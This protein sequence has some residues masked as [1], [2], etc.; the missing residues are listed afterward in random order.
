MNKLAV[1]AFT[2]LLFLSA[3]L[4]YLAKGSLND[5]LRSQVELQGHY[6][7]GQQAHIGQAKFLPESNSAQFNQLVLTNVKGYSQ[8]NVLTIDEITATLATPLTSTHPQQVSRNLNTSQIITV[9]KLTLNKV[10]VTLEKHKPSVSNSS[11]NIAVLTELVTL[12]LAKDYPAV[13][14]EVAAKLYAKEHPEL[15]AKLIN[16]ATEVAEPKKEIN[17]AIIASKA[18]KKQKKL[19]GKAQTRIAVQAIT[20][21]QLTLN[22]ID[23]EQTKVHQFNQVKLGTIGDTN[24]LASNQAGGEIL[25]VLLEKILTLQP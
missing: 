20:I 1:L 11:S 18:E 7:S 16:S 25:R 13:Y 24:G 12:Q 4:W 23:S 9:E 10:T 19:L 15:D 21:N 17:K 14:P 3:I 5:Y 22:I 8:S 2:I 6:Y